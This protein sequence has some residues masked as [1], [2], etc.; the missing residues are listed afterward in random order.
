MSVVNHLKRSLKNFKIEIQE[1][2]LFP[3]GGTVLWGPSGSGKSTILR[4]LLG[5]DPKAEVVWT[6][7]GQNLAE[8]P[9]AERRLG[10]VFQNP[11][12][13]PHMTAKQNILFP[14]QGKPSREWSKDFENLT[15]SFR[16]GDLLD[17]PAP[18]L[19]GGERQRVSLARAMIY[20]PQF[21]LL[22]EP[23]SALDFETAQSVRQMAKG[24]LAE[25]G[26]P[27]LLVTH[28]RDDVQCLP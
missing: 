14:V 16:L 27:F 2:Q 17:Q 5:L 24:F 9:L 19:S 8:L 13:F 11:A 20:G 7:G 22:D 28:N 23:F 25:K 4:A 3:E 15:E 10:A 1:W 18:L 6:L 12:L 21:L 26:C